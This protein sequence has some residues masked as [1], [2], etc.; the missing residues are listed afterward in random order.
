ML[1]CSSHY[2]SGEPKKKVRLIFRENREILHETG[3]PGDSMKNRESPAK[4]RRVG[5]YV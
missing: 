2:I 3:R 5:R 1:C 4:T